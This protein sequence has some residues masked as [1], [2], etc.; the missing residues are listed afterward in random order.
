MSESE[1]NSQQQGSD[2]SAESQDSGQDEGVQPFE[3]EYVEKDAPPAKNK[4]FDDE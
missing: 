1:D 2:Q 3:T 4:A